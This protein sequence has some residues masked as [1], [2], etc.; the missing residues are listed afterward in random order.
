[1]ENQF[2]HLHVHTEYSML[3]GASKIKD[4][5]KKARKYNMPAIAITDHGNMYGTYKFGM[6]I[7]DINKKIDKENEGKPENEKQPHFKGIFGCEFYVDANLNIKQGKPNLAHLICL[8]KNEEGLKN[9]CR[10]NSIAFVDG[11]YY[12]PRID[13]EVLEQHKE[14]LICL[15]AC[16]A[17]D[18]PSLL[19]ANRYDEAKALAL[20]LKNMFGDD[21][22][23]ELQNHYL[24]EQ[25]DVLPKLDKLAKELNI[26]TVA[27]NDVHYT[28]KE[29]AEVQD[30]LMCIQ[31]KKLLDDP[32]RMK[33][34]SDE[35]YFKSYEEMLE[36][37]PYYEEALKTT[38]EIANKCE[39]VVFKRKPLIPNYI[40]PEGKTPIEYLREITEAGLRKNYAEITPEIRKRV[41]YELGLI[42]KMN[43]VEYFLIVWDFVHYAEKSGLF[44]G[45]GRGSGAG[46]IVAYCMGITKVEPLKYN[47]LF[48]RFINPER[49]T[50]PDFDIDFQDDRRKEIIDYVTEKYTEPKVCGILAVSTMATKAVV[51]D[52]A[53]VLNFPYARVNEITKS[54]DLKSIQS[55]DKL[56]FIFGLNK[57][58]DIK[59]LN[60]NPEKEKMYREDL[61]H[62]NPELAEL[63]NND[64]SVK[65][66]IDL[67]VK[68]ENMPRGCSQHAAGVVICKEVISDNIPL[69]RNGENIT[70]QYDMIT[71]EELGFL[72]MDFL[73]LQTLTDIQKTLEYIKEDFGLELDPYKFDFEDQEVYKMISSGDTDAVFQLESP[74]MKKF[75]MDLKPDRFEDIIAGV[76][77][78]RPGPMDFIPDYIKNKKNPDQ[79]D[80]KDDT[81]KP[82]LEATYGVIVYQ[83]QVMQIV[84]EMAGYTLGQADMVRRMMSKKKHEA[85]AKER[86]SFLH[87]KF[88]D[89]GECI[90]EGA[91]KKG[92]SEEVSNE[93]YSRMETF[94][95]YA[96]N[97]SHAAAYAVLSI[98]TAHL[99]H[100]YFIQFFLAV[101][102]N[103]ISKPDDLKKYI[104]YL[105]SKNVKIL[106]PD[107][108][109]SK[110]FFSHEGPDVRYGLVALK[111]VGLN[112]I[113]SIIEERNN[114]GPYKDIQ[115]FIKRTYKYG[116]NKRVI[117][118]MILSGA[119][120]CFNV[121]R[122][123]MMG[124]YEKILEQVA[125]TN[126]REATGQFSMFDTLLKDE[127]S[128][129]KVEYPNIEEFDEQTK[130]KYE[131]DILGVYVS[132]HPLDKYLDKFNNYA[133][134]SSYLENSEEGED[135]IEIQ[136]TSEEEIENANAVSDG[137]TV[138]FGGIITAVKKIYTKRDNKE[139]AVVS[140]E[141]LYG[142]LEIMAFPKVYTKFKNLM[143]IDEIVEIT[144]KV[145]LRD[146][147]NPIILLENMSSFTKEEEKKEKKEEV[148]IEI[149]ETKEQK[150]YLRFDC[151]NEELKKEVFAI[152]DSYLGTTKVTIR[153]SKTGAL[154]QIPTTVNATN[155]LIYE[156][157]NSLG[158]N[159]VVLK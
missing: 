5:I 137:Q 30:V 13:Y 77:L 84:Q 138:T 33:F 27:T 31:M 68:L 6:E 54:I 2:V 38:V 144:G 147:Q 124:V 122:S 25:I 48:E 99:K 57:E 159:N 83:E 10:L 85:M 91:L 14:G 35:F 132:G 70:T 37:L 76:S 3:D 45:A 98:I 146:E 112:I 154:Y 81:L 158:D 66:L 24:P 117:E 51:K 102:N 19:L 134:N 17:G 153:C 79:I 46:S 126:K 59:E 34:G 7:Q 65:Q 29:D 87:G 42:E 148:K 92:H 21:F 142:G 36:V 156:L 90:A 11:F 41:D 32:N 157:Y 114:N 106:L 101:L 28:N 88:N 9:L 95:S 93:I 125:S 131:K 152:L 127:I 118:S 20:R 58:E 18:I 100:Y 96:F 110:T 39:E 49:V 141:D 123:Q 113:D 69:Q 86:Q 155:A 80:F 130:L 94:A 74:G 1:M 67:A 151:E 15:S 103:R 4:I 75:M 116:L 128:L 50:M 16:L 62:A 23:I 26:K 64:P 55:K 107:V 104:M 115:D 22:Y 60:L 136:T 56:A 12:K 78:Y 143:N 89:K 8:A 119:F 52:V 43:F 44:M 105:K 150:L 71:V 133:F 40:P 149:K 111:N 108:N 47:L 109:K 53:R 139:M 140:L 63:Y 120:D 135:T 61:K 121:K 97:K 145:N 73:G 129:N 82:I 72:K